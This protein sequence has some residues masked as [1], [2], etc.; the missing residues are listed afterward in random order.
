[1]SSAKRWLSLV[2]LGVPELL[3][4]GHPYTRAGSV[5][6]KLTAGQWQSLL[7]RG[8]NDMHELVKRYES[9]AADFLDGTAKELLYS[10]SEIIRVRQRF[11]LR[12]T[13]ACWYLPRRR[14]TDLLNSWTSRSSRSS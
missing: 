4:P 14:L 8:M 9:D 7:E 2:R 3:L 1:M 10:M 13:V 6:A 5:S 11:V 12:V